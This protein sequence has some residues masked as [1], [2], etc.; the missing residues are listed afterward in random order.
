M[1]F[2]SGISTVVIFINFF[3]SSL[4]SGTCSRLQNPE[5]RGQFV[6][7]KLN[8]SSYF[9]IRAKDLKLCGSQCLREKK[10]KSVNFEEEFEL[11]ELNEQSHLTSPNASLVPAIG[12]IY[13]PVEELEDLR[14]S[15]FNFNKNKH[16]M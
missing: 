16:D 13:M 10:C 9:A 8:V 5:P 6:D 3:Q 2:Y 4:A 12:V 14:V 1:Y 15:L 7:K 11:C